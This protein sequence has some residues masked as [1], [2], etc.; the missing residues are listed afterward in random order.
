MA[1]A[2]ARLSGRDFGIRTEEDLEK[3]RALPRPHCHRVK[4]ISLGSNG[5]GKSCLIKRHC[6]EQ[7]VTKYITTIGIDFGVK[8]THVQ[9]RPVKVHFWDLAGNQEYFEIRNEFYSDA[10]GALMVY[11]VTN[12]QSFLA[13]DGCLDEARQ[14]GLR[15]GMPIALC[16]NKSDLPSKKRV[17]TE[18]QGRAY[19]EARGLQ[20]FET[21]ANTG[22]QVPE[23]FAYLFDAAFRFSQPFA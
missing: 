23:L 11:D 1:V 9:G 20:Y 17:V 21:S 8:M 5:V 6:E 13:L 16:A 2:A 19:A 15:E 18:A 7:F 14:F 22:S 12:S 10:E 4:I 3:V